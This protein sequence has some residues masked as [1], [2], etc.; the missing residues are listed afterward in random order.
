MSDSPDPKVRSCF[1]KMNRLLAQH[2]PQP[3]TVDELCALLVQKT[4]ASTAEEV[5]TTLGADMEYKPLRAKEGGLQAMTMLRFEE[6]RAKGQ[7]QFVIIVDPHYPQMK[8]FLVGHEIAHIPSWPRYR[9]EVT[10]GRPRTGTMV[11]RFCFCFAQGAPRRKRD[12]AWSYHGRPHALVAMR[13]GG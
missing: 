3:E 2:E 13:C 4:G 5:A 9:A 8:P 6:E 11:R 1:V 10:E 7:G 12:E